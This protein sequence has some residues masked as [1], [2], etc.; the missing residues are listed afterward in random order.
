L[1]RPPSV[2]GGDVAVRDPLLRRRRQS[3]LR[4]LPAGGLPF[5]PRGAWAGRGTAGPEHGQ[6]NTR[7][8]IL[9]WVTT[10]KVSLPISTC[11]P[12][13]LVRPAP[14]PN[15]T[16]GEGHRVSIR[17][18]AERQ[19][20]VDAGLAQCLTG[21]RSR[22]DPVCP[23]PVPYAG[24]IGCNA[25]PTLSEVT[26]DAAPKAESTNPDTRAESCRSG[27]RIRRSPLDS[28]AAIS[29]L[30]DRRPRRTGPAFRRR[31][32]RDRVTG[33]GKSRRFR[34]S[35]AIAAA[36]SRPLGAS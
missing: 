16:H 13:E 10:R 3:G 7:T 6:R 27:A 22:A 30:A 14:A 18:V 36:S 2:D 25:Q 9:L 12:Q 4:L 35:A 19:H 21:R 34:T 17:R 32:N 29:A 23:A 31:S 11:T 33:N 15:R 8:G 1:A 26:E 24:A 20:R 5:A 28:V